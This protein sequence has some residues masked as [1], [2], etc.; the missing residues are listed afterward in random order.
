MLGT[1]ALRAV[2]VTGEG[3]S[4]LLAFSSKDKSLSVSEFV[5][6]RL[7][8]PKSLPTLGD[9]SAFE[10]VG[11]GSESRIVY[12]AKENRE[13]SP[14]KRSDVYVLRRLKPASV[15]SDASWTVDSLGDE[16]ELVV[17]LELKPA[18]IRSADV[19]GDARLDLIVFQQAKPPVILL[20]TDNGSYAQSTDT[21]R[22][23]LGNLTP[24]DVYYGPILGG[25]PAFLCTQ[26]G[27]AR[28]LR[29]EA[30][31]AWTV[32]DQYNAATGGAKVRGV[33]A[34]DLVGDSQLELAVYDRASQSIIF[35]REDAGLYR[36]WQRLKVGNFDL[37]GLVAS[38]FNNDGHPDILLY[39][40]EKMA[41]VYT[42]TKDIA[43]KVVAS[44]ETDNKE[45][46]LFDMVSGDLNADGKPDV[47]LLDPMD[48]NLEIVTMTA[49]GKL[50]RAVRWQV[51]EE[52]T[53][54]RQSS[55][56]EPRE[57]VIADLNG[58]QLEDIAILVHDRILVYLQD[59]GSDPAPVTAS[60]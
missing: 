11:K 57:A 44:Y 5:G 19:N 13:V 52:K 26:E 6:G 7:T 28:N 55:T 8:F 48:H 50:E 14:G 2:D 34:I 41:I 15:D 53:F 35:L 21:G 1:E 4:A 29:L 16:Q 20:A 43:L 45:G 17:K 3:Q 39:D 27:F 10:A 46:Q 36:A 23:T 9:V 32:V 42:K 59:D 51:F 38:D 56:I 58:D 18:D 33:L 54:N 24:A 60:Q 40:G 12:L 49:P 37:R 47:L 30:G 22:G 31:G 25:T